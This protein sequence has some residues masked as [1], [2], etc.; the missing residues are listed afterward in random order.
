MTIS[1]ETMDLTVELEEL[2]RQL[3]VS[4]GVIKAEVLA[5]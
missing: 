4:P 5:G 2:L 1:A 3:R